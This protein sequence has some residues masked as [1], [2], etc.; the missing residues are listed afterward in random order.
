[1]TARVTFDCLT[2]EQNKN[3]LV[4]FKI[5]AK[6]L[7]EFASVARKTEETPDGYQ[8]MFS[9]FRKKSI[10]KFID[11]GNIIPVSVL[12]SIDKASL[13]KDKKQITI[14]NS[15]NNAWIIDGQ[16]RTLGAALAEAEIELPVIAMLKAGQAEQVL[17]FVTINREAKGVP[18]SLYI[19]LLGRLPRELSP[20]ETAQNR[21]SDIADV[22]NKSETSPFYNRIAITSSPKAGQIS[23]SNFVR[24]VEPLVTFE[25]G[26]LSDFPLVQQTKIIE[27][28]FRAIEKVFNWELKKERPIFYQ[29]V[30]FGAF[31][32]SFEYIFNTIINRTNGSFTVQDI[33]GLLKEVLEETDLKDGIEGWTQYGTGEKAENNAA[34][35]LKTAI[36]TIISQ[37]EFKTS[38]KL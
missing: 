5:K 21:A 31:M 27:N 29:T 3:T 12:I 36:T 4:L 6:E 14:E 22:L 30:G 17:Q 35:E 25:R 38:I 7:L 19:D 32:K 10:A 33:I 2:F 20:K 37:S 23:K 9:E 24:K 16:H 13:S 1:M 18:S 11:T 26:K 34:S 8:R 15:P 28:Y